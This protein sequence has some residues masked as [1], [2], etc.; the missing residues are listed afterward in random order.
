MLDHI[1]LMC[2]VCAEQ[3]QKKE[4]AEYARFHQENDPSIG[5]LIP[6]RA[7]DEGDTFW[8]HTSGDVEWWYGLPQYADLAE[9]VGL[10]RRE[11]DHFCHREQSGLR[12]IL[13]LYR[14]IAEE[15]ERCAKIADEEM[16][17]YRDAME[18]ACRADFGKL[19]YAVSVCHLIAQRIRE[20]KQ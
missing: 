1:D 10:L 6:A 19:D 2:A 4:I 18:G 11:R 20:G 15:R 17:D 14:G 12:E 16:Q 9:E 7:T 3:S 13:G 5:D 8:G